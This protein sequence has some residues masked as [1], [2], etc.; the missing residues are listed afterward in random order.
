MPKSTPIILP[1]ARVTS[2]DD[3]T[4]LIPVRT[5]KYAEIITSLTALKPGQA[6]VFAFDKDVNVARVRNALTTVLQNAKVAAPAGHA[7]Y[8]SVGKNNE[9]VIRVLPRKARSAKRKSAK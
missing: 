4:K 3:A 8:K 5:S 7:F 9:L 1:K 6:A 2:A